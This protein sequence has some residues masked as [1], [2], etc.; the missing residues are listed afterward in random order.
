MDGNQKRVISRL[1][2]LKKLSKH[3]ELR[4]KKKLKLLV[5]CNRPGDINQALMDI[6]SLFCKSKIPI[7]RD[8][9]FINNCKAYESG[10]PEN[11]PQAKRQKKIRK[12]I[13][14]I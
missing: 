12:I 13:Q 10:N 11:Y 8:C 1:L 14:K 9:I 7:C 5:S 6:G 2:G 4:I 3:N